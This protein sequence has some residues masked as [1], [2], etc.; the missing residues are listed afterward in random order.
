MQVILSFAVG[1][2]LYAL[3]DRLQVK[4]VLLELVFTAAFVGA[5]A[6]LM[7]IGNVQAR[8]VAIGIMFVLTGI[9]ARLVH[10][11][12]PVEAPEKDVT[13]GIIDFAWIAIMGLAL[14]IVCFLRSVP[15]LVDPLPRSGYSHEYYQMLCETLQFFMGWVINAV[16][17][18][19]ATLA[20]GMGILWAGELWTRKG[21][22]VKSEYRGLTV[23]AIKMVTAFFVV[24]LAFLYWLAVPLYY[25]IIAT[26]ELL[27]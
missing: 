27:K 23:A 14:A 15:P 6:L 2:L 13:L 24:V 10:G 26:T 1:R 3:V 22:L 9:A 4:L 25:R 19:G 12:P 21:K 17:I 20:A 7:T 11:K 18:L 16:P 5:T 8:S